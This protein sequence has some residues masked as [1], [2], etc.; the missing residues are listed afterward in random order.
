ML[1]LEEPPA[2]YRIDDHEFPEL[3]DEEFEAPKNGIGVVEF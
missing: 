2:N 1:E 3:S